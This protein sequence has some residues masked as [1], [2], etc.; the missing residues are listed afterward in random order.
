MVGLGRVEA[1]L[2][3]S[4][5]PGVDFSQGSGLVFIPGKDIASPLDISQTAS[6]DLD[7]D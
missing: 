3:Q 4:Y 2:L 7:E 6:I 1:E 5:D